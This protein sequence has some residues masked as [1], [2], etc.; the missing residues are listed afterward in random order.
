[1]K[2]DDVLKIAIKMEEDGYDFYKQAEA[3]TANDMGKRMYSFLADY[4]LHHKELLLSLMNKITP[5]A[6][7]LDIPLPKDRLKS[8]FAEARAHMDK[9]VP[10]T[11]DDIAALDF[12]MVK[13]KESFKLYAEA[14]R[15]SGD[16]KVKAVFARMAKEEGQHYEI[17]EHTRYYLDQYANWSIWEEGGPIEGG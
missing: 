8:V 12:A 15:D 16:P 9:S 10:A 1:M 17:L 2:I 14:A 4:E 11:A 13:E 5:D 7:E 3:R 6:R